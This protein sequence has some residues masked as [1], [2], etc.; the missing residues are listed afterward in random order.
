MRLHL[1]FGHAVGELFSAVDWPVRYWRLRGAD[2]LSAQ[3]HTAQRGLGQG[4]GVVV[5]FNEWFFCHSRA[6][7][8]GVCSGNPA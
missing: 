1:F 3:A 5:G 6:S 4:G 7:D 8:G 2:V